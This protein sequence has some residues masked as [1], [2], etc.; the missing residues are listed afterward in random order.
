MSSWKSVA[1]LPLALALVLPL[2]GCAGGGEAEELTPPDEPA[3][4]VTPSATPTAP[5]LAF[6]LPETCV[7]VLPDTRLEAFEAGGLVLLGGPGGKYGD[8]Y[9]LDATPE[10]KAGG[11]TCIWGFADSEMSS[12]TIS[13][14]PL[15]P[16]TRPDVVES[17]AE[18]GLNEDTVGGASTFSVQG[19]KQLNPA[20]FN[21][22]RAESW[23]SVIQTVGGPE[24][25]TE[26]VAIA[27]EI[28]TQV[29][30]P[31]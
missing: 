18:Q 4:V 13:I 20:I 12:I 3:P 29:Y 14:A 24:A 8:D 17:F 26:A 15:T 28:Y 16:A 19:D 21:S 6:T 27:D 5:E 10:Q 31:E 9:L 30:Q 22:L 25:Y 1:I 11:I 23:I 2:A 7:S